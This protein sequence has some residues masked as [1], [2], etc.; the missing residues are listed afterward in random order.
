MAGFHLPR[1]RRKHALAL[2]ALLAL[3]GCGF[4]LLQPKSEAAS[5]GGPQAL[6]QPPKEPVSRAAEP[7][8]EPSA[9]RALSEPPSSVMDDVQRWLGFGLESRIQKL[10]AANEAEAY[11]YVAETLM[12]ACGQVEPR[13]PDCARNPQWLRERDDWI[14]AALCARQPGAA[15]LRAQSAPDSWHVM[16]SRADPH[17]LA[18]RQREGALLAEMEARNGSLV[19]L[20]GLGAFADP[21][22]LR[23]DAATARYVGL[24]ALIIKGLRNPPAE[25]TPYLGDIERAVS[26]WEERR[27]LAL[28]GL[29]AEHQ[30]LAAAVEAD[31]AQPMPTQR[32]RE[33]LDR[34]C[35]NPLSIRLGLKP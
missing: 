29:D 21:H 31:W 33:L 14:D 19:T 13:H 17:L 4:W 34:A 28:A 30:A 23:N 20:I 27:Q 10:L 5:E 6:A 2:V 32:Q 12:T 7:S 16:H 18:E 25:L 1:F 15:G 22:K 26:Q 8:A 35:R 9:A 3:L 11:A 24:A